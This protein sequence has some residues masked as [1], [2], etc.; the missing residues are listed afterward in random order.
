MR[1]D[2]GSGYKST[3]VNKET[4]NEMGLS[5]TRELA[6]ELSTKWVW[7]IGPRL[8]QIGLGSVGSGLVWVTSAWIDLARRAVWLLRRL[9]CCAGLAVGALALGWPA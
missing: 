6:Y 3:C 2:N 8:G 4:V 9:G 7:A 5:R 1:D